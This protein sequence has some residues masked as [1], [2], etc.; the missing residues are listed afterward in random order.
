[1]E[2]SRGIIGLS[3]GETEIP[4]VAV[5]DDSSLSVT[6]RLAAALDAA[7]LW[8]ALRRARRDREAA[9]LRIVI[10]PELRGFAAGSPTATDPRL[11]EDLLDLLYDQGFSGAAIVGTR[12]SSAAWAENR[13]LHALA[14]LLGYRY[15]TPKGRSYDILDLAEDL[16]FDA[17]PLGCVLHGCAVSRHWFNAD[18][19]VVFSKSRSDE[20]SGY[21]LCLD[22]LIDVL[23]LPDKD[24]HYRRRRDSGDVVAALLDTAPVQFSLI[25]GI[26]GAHGPGGRRAPSA[27]SNGTVIGASDIILADYAGALK[28]G[29]DPAISP[30]VA[31][32]ICRHPMPQRYTVTG[33]LG[34]WP[35]WQNV[36]PTALEST[37]LRQRAEWLDQLFEP[38]LQC[39]DSELFPLKHPLDARINSWLAPFFADA[40]NAWLL[41]TMNG[42]LGSVGQ[43]VEMYRTMFDKD[44]LRH[45]SVPLGID[46]DA[47]PQSA[48]PQ[49]V[50]ELLQLE[51]VA[52][53][54]P[55]MS[56]ELCWRDVGD[57]VVFRYARS[58]P[59]DFDL[60][61]RRVDIART[62][63][64]MN[65]YLGGVLIPLAYDG[66]GR[67][68]HQ[69]ERN[70]YLPQPNYLALYQGKPIDVSKLEVVQYGFDRHRLFWKTIKSENDSATY[71]DGIATF[72]RTPDAT[73]ITITGRQQFTLPPFWQVF[74]PSFVPGL[75]QKLVTHAYQTF[76]DRTIS[77]LE[78]LVEGREIRIGRPV[79]EPATPPVEMLTA[80]LQRLIEIAAPL[81]A[82]LAGQKQ[83]TGEQWGE[84]DV[85]GFT[86]IRPTEVPPTSQEHW[87]TELS[88]FIE[89]LNQAIGRDLLQ[90]SVIP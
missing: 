81:L 4:A 44:A 32:V 55:P 89:G 31:R 60:F 72:E 24:T 69:A 71:D 58:L 11:V 85:D 68:V 15:E 3:G 74:D 67:P 28:M 33:S 87:V 50:E 40:S 53:T 77:N 64:F 49:L 6:D 75:K 29:L 5:V 79:D 57:C 1:V 80:W 78:A 37:R 34:R 7:G 46:L 43:A 17:F 51:P 30:T 20:A 16:V 9:D 26:V 83:R 61:T 54:S 52:A 14:D 18:F 8:T 73:R 76:F 39:L 38:W 13:D 56:P 35:E 70:I 42:L 82:Q 2:S 21:A 88:R 47:I 62:I 45:C 27:I 12:D 22:T 84:T 86:H 19:R 90:S 63:Q 59:I 10:K 41:T 36:A 25:D 66:A 65:D 23:P 48:F